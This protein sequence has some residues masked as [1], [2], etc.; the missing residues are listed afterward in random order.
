MSITLED[1]KA[2]EKR[3]VTL[4]EG[5]NVKVA[6]LQK[7]ITEN[8][9]PEI[10]RLNKQL[11]GTSQKQEQYERYRPLIEF[12]EG[13][14]KGRTDLTLTKN[15]STFKVQVKEESIEVDATTIAGQILCFALEGK[16]NQTKLG[17]IM[18]LLTLGGFHP[19][20]TSVASELERL[21]RMGALTRNYEKGQYIYQPSP[22]FNTLVKKEVTPQKPS[23]EHLRKEI[24]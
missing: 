4:E 10:E 21:V 11:E 17:D 23:W 18:K 16:L 20:K 14:F 12:L 1:L 8:Y 15:L 7:D 6:A 19:R 5:F 2:L 3:I 9:K 22:N 13:F 24:K